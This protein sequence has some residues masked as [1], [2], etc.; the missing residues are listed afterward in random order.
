M[1]EGGAR[2]EAG[3]SLNQCAAAVTGDQFQK[4]FGAAPVKPDDGQEVLLLLRGKV[5]N[6]AG[7]LAVDVAG[8]DHEYLV[9]ARF[10]L[11]P[12]EKPQFAGHGAGI[13][14]V[15]ADGDHDVHRAGLDEFLA[16]LGLV[17]A[18]TGGLAGHDEPGP[19]MVV[20]VAVKVADPDV[21]AV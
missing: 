14:E 1:K 20:E 21:V 3:L 10:G 5:I 15:G 7:H 18:R 2:L 13:E 19:A 11:G 8:V 12:V 6:F 9:T 17:A 16:D 4:F